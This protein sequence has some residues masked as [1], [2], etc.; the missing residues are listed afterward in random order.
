MANETDTTVV[1][2]PPLADQQDTSTEAS[3]GALDRYAEGEGVA[4]TVPH[5]RAG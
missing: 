5:R 4:V 2:A 1:P 3:P